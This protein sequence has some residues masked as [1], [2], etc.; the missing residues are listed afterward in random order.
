VEAT[1]F[2]EVGYH[3]RDVDSIIKDLLDV[4]LTLVKELKSESLRE[5]I[6]A[7]VEARLLE[8]I[9]GPAAA[10]D[11]IESFRALLREGAL[12]ER[13]VVV[14]VPVK[15]GPG[16]RG[17][18]GGERGGG[19][20]GSSASGSGGD[21]EV[22]IV[23]GGSL[24][25]NELMSRLRG[26]GGGR[27]GGGSGGAGGAGGK[28]PL[29]RRWMKVREARA[30]L[31]EAELDRRL[32]AMDLRREAVVLAEENGIVF[33]DEIDKLIS[34]KSKHSGDA[35]SEGVQRDLLP[36]IEGTS[37]EVRCVRCCRR[38]AAPALAACCAALP[39]ALSRPPRPRPPPSAPRA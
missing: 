30:A 14:E 16:G 18:G 22:S 5:E 27:G 6:R 24:D 20:S 32:S 34:N 17:G 28:V 9:T 39:S 11:T 26:E 19:G 29:T 33:I 37:I 3:G 25:F 13:E 21:M 8:A 12:D 15:E 2:T 31:E 36:L 7:P 23:S 10:E 1:K 35:S 4:S 38:R